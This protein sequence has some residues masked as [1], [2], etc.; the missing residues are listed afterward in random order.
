MLS[1]IEKSEIIR[2]R[3]VFLYNELEEAY[4]RIE[5]GGTA[6]FAKFPGKKEYPIKQTS[7]MVTQ[8][9]ISFEEVS[10]EAYYNA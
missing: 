10:K 4:V 5:K 2:S 9:I 8:A 7:N 6:F 3:D 1:E